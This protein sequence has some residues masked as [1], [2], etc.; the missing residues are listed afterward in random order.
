MRQLFNIIIY[1]TLV[2]LLS[3]T[4]TLG[5]P[6]HHADSASDS[7]GKD[8]VQV[9]TQY[10]AIAERTRVLSDRVLGHLGVHELGQEARDAV[11]PA[12]THATHGAQAALGGTDRADKLAGTAVGLTGSGRSGQI[13]ST[14]ARDHAWSTGVNLEA[15]QRIVE[16]TEDTGRV[17]HF[18]GV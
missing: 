10:L 5:L 17:R 11:V 13:S 16:A 3:A 1:L 18:K 6:C 12:A 14:T 9:R 8:K 2:R 15:N 4:L 7:A